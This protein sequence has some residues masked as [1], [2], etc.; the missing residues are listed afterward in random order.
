MPSDYVSQKIVEAEFAV[1]GLVPTRA[2]QIE[3]EMKK[4][5][6]F[7]FKRLI[8]SNQGNP[9]L[10][11]ARPLSYPRQL[12]SLID[13]PF[14]LKHP[15][16]HEMFPRDVIARARHAVAEISGSKD[17]DHGT[18]AYTHVQG[19][20][21]V[22]RNI[23]EFITIRDRARNPSL[24][25][26]NPDNIFI[27]DGAT[28][29][30]H[31]LLQCLIGDDKDALLLPIPQYPLYS[32]TMTMLGGKVSPYYLDE[33]N[34]WALRV[35]EME[36]AYQ[37]A[38]SA[39][40]TP[41]VV[42]IVNPGNPTGQVLLREEIEAC[43]KWAHEKNLIVIA[44]EVYQSNVYRE[45]RPFYSFREVVLAWP[46]P[47][48]NEAQIVSFHSASK[49][50]F[51]ECGRRGGYMELMNISPKLIEQLLK[52]AS[53]ALCS[54][55]SGQIMVDC[56]VRHPRPFEESYEPF[57]KE[58]NAALASLKRRAIRIVKGF[59]AI[60][61]LKCTPTDGAMYA[62]P[63]LTFPE[64]FMRWNEEQNKKNKTKIA[65]DARW[66]LLLLERTGIVVVPGSGFGQMP[67]TWHFR[68]TILPPED[69]VEDLIKLVKTFQSEFLAKFGP[70]P[71][72]KKEK[73]SKL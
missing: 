17:K 12:L 62:Y 64:K 69:E 5:K 18:G 42:V 25:P 41:R 48:R 45:D 50:V 34:G 67:G 55:V 37:A 65:P 57:Y 72:G 58:Y 3:Q 54:N 26:A 10:V 49:G 16:V 73:K 33:A 15:K 24:P 46:E 47:M 13:S 66:S 32:A 14:L 21:F 11:G 19:Y 36:R 27:T 44:D 31:F 7:P 61:G 29:G 28:T 60:P 51:G 53:V 59:N 20:E 6:K 56:M 35:E 40:Q 52:V 23:A 71:G 22:R 68:T 4:G 30:I 2:M 70:L 39:G 38:V 8:Q 1:K 9:Q 43:A 63:A